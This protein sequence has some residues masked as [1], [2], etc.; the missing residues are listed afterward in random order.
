MSSSS[1][2]I[3]I[4]DDEPIK[5]YLWLRWLKYLLL[6]ATFNSAVWGL[7]LTYLKK[8]PPTFISELIIHVAGSSPG[9]SVNLPSIGQANTSSGTSFGSHSDP[10]ENYK[11]MATSNTVL[12]TAA[13]SL[14]ISVSK[15]GKP[16]V[17][18]INNTTLLQLE[19][20]GEDP[21]VAESKAWAL[22]QSLYKRLNVLRSQEQKE[23]DKSV[24]QI[25]EDT[26]IKLT[27]AQNQLSGYKLKSGFNSS[28]QI[29][30]LIGNM[31]DLQT[32]LIDAIAQYR[33]TNDNL[34]QLVST[35]RVSPQKAADALVLQTDQ[36]FQKILT[37]YTDATTIL[38]NLL[39][40][41]GHNYPDVV[42]ARQKQQA[43]LKVLLQRGQKLLGIPVEQLSLERLI[44]D[45][46]NGSGVKRGDLFVQLVKTNAEL[47]GLE[48]QIATL[49]SQITE[50]KAELNILTEKET[51][52]DHLDR[53]LQ[54]A[55]AV[56]ASTL[57]KIDL[58]KGDPFASFPMIQIIE[59]PTLP[60]EPSAPK[61]KL[62]LA[63]AFVGSLFVTVGLTLLWWREPLLKISKQIVKK[64]IE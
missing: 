18:L 19:V 36:E 64:A 1:E 63:G 39:P 4:I 28:D 35:L 8:T 59:E 42:E 21:K 46:S 32:K 23:R 41:R 55:Q 3:T 50:Q 51:I 20:S 44:L 17:T 48:G 40:N 33:Q 34:Q 43:S 47:K 31:G 56:F 14:E 57:T 13:E 16:N 52:H 9:V 61:P 10:R 2:S 11:L 12:R 60:E 15:L 53:D 25:L 54:I 29:T 22:Y 30:N 27:E 26:R 49:K 58:S 5:K 24:Q 7:A 6:A 38:T 37:E 45:N 62:V